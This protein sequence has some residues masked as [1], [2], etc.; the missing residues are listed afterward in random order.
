MKKA[1]LCLFGIS[2]LESYRHWTKKYELNIDYKDSLN[3]YR[4]YLIDYYR[5][6]GYE[7]DIF[8]STYNSSIEKQLLKDYNPKKYTLTKFNPFESNNIARNWHF[9]NVLNLVKN[10][11]AQNKF[12]YDSIMITRFDIM[13]IK[14]IQELKIFHDKFNISYKCERDPLIDDNFYVF[15][16][17]YLIPFITLL[18]DLAPWLSYH[19]IY[20]RLYRKIRD[21]N[22]MIN[23]NYWVNDNPIYKLVRNKKDTDAPP[24][25]QITEKKIG[26]KILTITKLNPRIPQNNNIA[27]S[28]P[29]EIIKD[30]RIN[31]STIILSTIKKPTTKFGK[32]PLVK[33][34]SHKIYLASRT[35]K[36]VEPKKMGVP[37]WI[38]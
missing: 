30:R 31:K 11:C 15:H 19:K 3:N 23:G 4:E 29:I 18:S 28:N 33:N 5:R 20:E 24:K 38:N 25:N 17:K 6:E 13:F 37:N 1:C 22:F 32:I 14:N 36:K 7:L 8:I 2:K 26:N 27:S 16:G 9:I 21:I 35:N 10:H 34:N 12:I